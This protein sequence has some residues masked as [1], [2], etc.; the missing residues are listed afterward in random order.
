MFAE[1]VFCALNNMISAVDS[2]SDPKLLILGNVTILV[3]IQEGIFFFYKKHLLPK[4]LMT[5]WF[6]LKAALKMS[7]LGK[8][9]SLILSIYGPGWIKIDIQQ[10]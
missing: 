5:N 7:A 4:M 2:P 3:T 8:V 9:F 6:Q 10:K 1:F